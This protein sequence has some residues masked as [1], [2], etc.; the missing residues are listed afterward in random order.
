MTDYM[1][2]SVLIF[3]NLILLAG[4]MVYV[5]KKAYIQAASQQ[6]LNENCDKN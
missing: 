1:I 5:S 2:G 4:L 6:R 3:L